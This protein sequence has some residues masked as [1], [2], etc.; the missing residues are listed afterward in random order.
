MILDVQNIYDTGCSGILR[1]ISVENLIKFE[2]GGH[3]HTH[4][5]SHVYTLMNS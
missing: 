1:Y 2:N 5:Q 4:T 3:T